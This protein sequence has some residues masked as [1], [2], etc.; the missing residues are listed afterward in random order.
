MLSSNW[1]ELNADKTRSIWIGTWQQLAKGNIRDLHLLS[2]T[3]HFTDT[4]SLMWSLT[5]S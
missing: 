1:L 5:V 3:I 4:V 2:A